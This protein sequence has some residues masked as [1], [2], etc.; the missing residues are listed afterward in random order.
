MYKDACLSLQYVRGPL[1]T[2]YKKNQLLVCGLPQGLEKDEYEVIISDCLEMEESEFEIVINY[3]STATINFGKDFSFRGSKLLVLCSGYDTHYDLSVSELQIMRNKIAAKDIDGTVVT[4]EM[5]KD[6]K[7]SIH[8]YNIPSGLCD[9]EFL[10]L[11]FSK[12]ERSRGGEIESITVLGETE[13]IITFVDP[14][15]I[16]FHRWLISH[17]VR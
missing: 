16:S 9:E 10:R 3:D 6:A 7:L 13:A 14:K 15:G 1:K 8:V 4:V 2:D 12:P 5:V 11:Y 17:I